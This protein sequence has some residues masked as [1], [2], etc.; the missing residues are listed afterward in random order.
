[1]KI[2]TDSAADL[3]LS[4]VESNQIAVAPL[5]ISFPEGEVR[6][7]DISA[8]EFYNRLEA[9]S[10]RI[11]TTSQP[12]PGTFLDIYEKLAHAGE[13]ILSIQISSGLSG[14]FQAA[15]LA[16]S[17]LSTASVTVFDSLTLSG[18]LRFQVL[19]AAA[20]ARAGWA[21]DK[22][23]NLLRYVQEQCEVVYTL[24]TLD[25]LARGGR[26]GRVQALA[27][28]L[29]HLKPVIDVNKGDG[30][31]STVG[32]A[33]TLQRAQAAIVD[34]LAQM[35]GQTPVW[36]TVMHGRFAEQADVLTAALRERLCCS[37]LEVLRISPALGVHTGPGIV[38]AAVMPMALWDGIGL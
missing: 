29:L 22:I 25:Y 36:V 15:R 26:I 5:L 14:T 23:L 2:V 11:P 12:S 19:A 28:A 21:M 3:P 37:K 17:Q 32:K 9:M 30:K 10:P 8:D 24:D 13:E 20:A 31:Y 35:Y 6:S 1:M 38:G 33:R 18:G 4:E 34:H 7:V 27:G 16:A